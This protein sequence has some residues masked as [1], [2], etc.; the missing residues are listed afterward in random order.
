MWLKN[1]PCENMLFSFNWLEMQVKWI[2]NLIE[3]YITECHE[4]QDSEHSQSALCTWHLVEYRDCPE[5]YSRDI[6]NND[7]D[8]PGRFIEENL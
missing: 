5:F 8:K 1:R 3:T 4:K 6:F 7:I 2:S